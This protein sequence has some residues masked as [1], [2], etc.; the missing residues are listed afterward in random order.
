[1]GMDRQ[2]T[3]I[4]DRLGTGEAGEELVSRGYNRRD[5]G[6]IAA[7]LGGGLA[8]AQVAPAIA[9]APRPVPGMV[10]LESNECWTGPF[11]TGADAAMR[12]IA[13][14]NR[15]EPDGDHAELFAAVTAVEGVPADRILGWPGSSDPLCRSAVSFASPMRG[16]VTA[17]PT[18]EPI[19]MTGD[20]LGAKVSKVP[21]TPDHRHDVRAMLAADPSAGL[22]YICSP[23]N[24]TGTLTPVED[25]AW[26]AEHKAKD[27]VILVDEAYIHF[28][29]A[30]SA[31]KLAAT[32]DDVIVMRTFSKLFGMAGM[33]LGLTFASQALHQRMMRYDG[34]LVT[35]MLPMTAVACATASLPLADQI[36]ARRAQMVSVRDETIAHLT[37]RGL[38]TVPGSRA[39]MFMVEWKTATPK[40]MT[41]AFLD[42]GVQI[43][44][45]W[46]ALPAMSRITVGSGEDMQKFRLALDRILTA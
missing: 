35:D 44:R 40:A 39:N 29:G 46:T 27:A 16:I 38:R 30:P 34:P 36:A 4:E 7:L 37:R 24:P 42:Q 15:Y 45:S 8:A 5:F 3:R 10:R 23:N 20:W 13:T 2:H 11:P 26:L 6:R 18:F 12:A 1:M 41:A 28:A 19:W 14:S 31:A 32:R 43:G 9:Q 21:L 17:D 25:I 22:Y 33:R